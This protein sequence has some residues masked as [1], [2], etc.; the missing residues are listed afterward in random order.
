[1]VLVFNLLTTVIMVGVGGDGSRD[2]MDV[3][4]FIWIM[5][6]KKGLNDVSL[7]TKNKKKKKW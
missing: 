7:D 1:M 2:D 5:Q 6:F 4:N 3:G